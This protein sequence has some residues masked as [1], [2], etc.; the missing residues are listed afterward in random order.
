MITAF[1]MLAMMVLDMRIISP[2]K[3][4]QKCMSYLVTYIE[5]MMSRE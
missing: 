4:M 3:E 2:G 5:T 1:E